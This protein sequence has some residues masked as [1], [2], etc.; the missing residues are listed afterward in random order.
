ML[1]RPATVED[2]DAC[3]KVMVRAMA[4]S[5]DYN[6]P[7]QED[8]YEQSRGRVTGYLAGSYHPG[9]SL[10]DRAVFVA[11][12]SGEV[13]AFVA[14]H[15]TLRFGCD[16]ELQWA[17]VHPDWQGR[18]ISTSLLASLREWFVSRG[19]KKVCVNAPAEMLNREFYLKHGAVPLSEHWCVWNDIGAKG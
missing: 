17:F 3:A 2:A 13:I 7:K 6:Y 15:R 19:L 12:N 18:G 5:P 1:I 10:E 9:F 16:G 8:I 4:A 11:E 14:G